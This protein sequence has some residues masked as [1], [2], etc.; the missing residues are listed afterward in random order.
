MTK[1]LINQED[2][3]LLTY[4]LQLEGNHVY[5]AATN[6]P[7][8]DFKSNTIPAEELTVLL[9]PLDKSMKQNQ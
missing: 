1:G 9:S 6:N 3:L 8:R 4:M 5:K 2:I 7:K